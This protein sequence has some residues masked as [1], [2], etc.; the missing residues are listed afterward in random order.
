MRLTEAEDGGR[1]PL[2]RVVGGYVETGAERKGIDEPVRSL[3]DAVKPKL[4]Y[5]YDRCAG[6]YL[7]AYVE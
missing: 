5:A 1:S 4:H 7:R 3:Y 2:H 6:A